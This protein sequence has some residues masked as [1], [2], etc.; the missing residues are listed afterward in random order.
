MNH[1]LRLFKV[2]KRSVNTSEMFNKYYDWLVS[3]PPRYRPSW[4]NIFG[5]NRVCIDQRLAGYIGRHRQIEKCF[6]KG[7]N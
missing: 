4:T 7:W 6:V 3:K 5:R 2:C 1:D